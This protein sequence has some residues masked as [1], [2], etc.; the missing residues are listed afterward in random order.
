MKKKPLGILASSLMDAFLEQFKTNKEYILKWHMS[1]ED[2]AQSVLYSLR[3]QAYKRKVSKSLTISRT[4]SI[5][6]IGRRK[7]SQ[8][9]KLKNFILRLANHVDN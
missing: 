1:G 2:A 7:E 5:V 4:G 8:N 9:Q 6:F 3:H